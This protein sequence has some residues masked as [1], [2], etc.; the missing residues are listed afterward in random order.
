MPQERRRARL[1]RILDLSGFGVPDGKATVVVRIDCLEFA[2]DS[3]CFWRRDLLGAFPRACSNV[4]LLHA[5]RR[6]ECPSVL[7]TG[8]DTAEANLT[9]YRL[10]RKIMR[11][12][13]RF[14][15]LAVCLASAAA[16]PAAA[17]TAGKWEIEFHGGGMLP[18]NPAGG[19][20]SLPPQGELFTSVTN[21]PALG[22]AV[23]ASRRQSSWYF[24]D[25]AILFNGLA[26]TLVANNQAQFSGRITPLDL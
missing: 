26:D 19:T 11:T 23:H 1:V 20:V 22:P 13:N 18:T 2:G 16:S 6:H 9:R 15:V 25:G 8:R 12:R 14:C 5:R 21:V 3:V 4:S 10:G 24:G 17:Q 7:H